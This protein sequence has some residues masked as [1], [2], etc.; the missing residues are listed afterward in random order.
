MTGHTMIYDEQSLNPVVCT[1]ITMKR[2]DYRKYLTPPFRHKRSG[3]LLK[4]THSLS[5]PSDR[6]AFSLETSAI[7][8]KRLLELPIFDMFFFQTSP[9][10]AGEQQCVPDTPRQ[11]FQPP[12]QSLQ[13]DTRPTFDY[14]QQVPSTQRRRQNSQ[15]KAPHMGPHRPKGAEDY[16]RGAPA[17]AQ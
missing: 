2:K 5:S 8:L 6:L 9:S 17:H 16:P 10:S 14:L 13:H 12:K 3:E 4:R 7:K 1:D 11:A 15:D